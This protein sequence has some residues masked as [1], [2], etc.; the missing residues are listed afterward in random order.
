MKKA[1][2]GICGPGAREGVFQEKAHIK[3]HPHQ[4]LYPHQTLQVELNQAQEA[5]RRQEQQ[6]ASAEEQLKFVVS[7]M[8]R[9]L[10]Q[11]SRWRSLRRG[12]HL[13]IIPSLPSPPTLRTVVGIEQG[14][15]RPALKQSRAAG[16]SCGL[17]AQGWELEPCAGLPPSLS[18]SF[19][20]LHMCPVWLGKTP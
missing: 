1:L 19:L 2:A 9:Y 12:G 17:R 14:I 20:R 15:L 4:T 8:N 5:R 7:A 3:L 6:A 16:R 10:S 11:S 18:S 13:Y